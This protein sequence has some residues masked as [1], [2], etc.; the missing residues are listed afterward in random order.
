MIEQP[1]NILEAG[2]TEVTTAAGGARRYRKPLKSFRW[3]DIQS[4][5]AASFGEWSKRQLLIL[6]NISV[7]K[8]GRNGTTPAASEPP[9][10]RR[11]A[12]TAVHDPSL[13]PC[14]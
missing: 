14:E 3:R 6:M 9:V 5:F 2:G 1:Q 8:A 7:L 10:I 12:D 13:A 11:L 4:I